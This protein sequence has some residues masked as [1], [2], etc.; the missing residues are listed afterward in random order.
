[1]RTSPSDPDDAHRRSRVWVALGLVILLA[2]SLAGC[3]DAQLPPVFSPGSAPDPSP[4]SSAG[5]P[6]G[7]LDGLI[8]TLRE[9]TQTERAQAADDL[10]RLADPAAIPALATALADEDWTVRWRAAEALTTLNDERAVDAL[11]DLVAVAP[12]EPAVSSLRGGDQGPWPDRR[13]ARRS[14]SR[15]DRRCQRIDDGFRRGG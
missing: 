11:L 13:P 12:K 1:M 9:G 6:A 14:A 10:A 15:G 7:D 3:E 4:G 2:G 5:V 8:A